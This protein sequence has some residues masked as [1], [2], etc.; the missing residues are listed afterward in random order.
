MALPLW[1][2]WTLQMRTMQKI[3]VSSVFLLA[4]VDIIFD[5]VRTAYTTRQGAV[6]P[7]TVFDALVGSIAVIVCALPTYYSLVS[8]SRRRSRLPS[9]RKQDSASYANLK[10]QI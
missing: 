8:S 6:A 5:I 3:G 10:D 1:K 7:Y 4:T 9:E 2:I